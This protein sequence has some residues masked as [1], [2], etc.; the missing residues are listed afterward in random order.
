[1]SILKPVGK[2]AADAPTDPNLNR[3]CSAGSA[4]PRRS[5]GAVGRWK[6]NVGRAEERRAREAARGREEAIVGMLEPE[7]QCGRICL[8]RL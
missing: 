5:S 8:G 2:E 7:T 4:S 6:V 1:M 3:G